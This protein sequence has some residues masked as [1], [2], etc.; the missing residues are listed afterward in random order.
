M[1]KSMLW[2]LTSFRPFSPVHHYIL[3]KVLCELQTVELGFAY[4]NGGKWAVWRTLSLA[5]SSYVIC[6]TQCRL[7]MWD[8]I[9]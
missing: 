3:P 7:R 2:S 4:T 8:F 9:H 5:M 1:L 6:R